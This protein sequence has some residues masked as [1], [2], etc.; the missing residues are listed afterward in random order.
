M[1]DVLAGGYQQQDVHDI[2]TWEL[3]TRFDR[4]Y[5]TMLRLLQEAWTHGDQSF[6][7]QAIGEM[8]TMSDLAQQ[9]IKIPKPDDSGNYGPCFRYVP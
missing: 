2:A 1:A 7:R 5:S 4:E 8:F 9:L 3:I 6:L